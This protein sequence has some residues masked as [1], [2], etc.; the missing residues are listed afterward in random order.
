MILRK[1]KRFK[2]ADEKITNREQKWQKRWADAN[3]FTADIKNSSK[4]KKYLLIEFPYPSGIGLHIGHMLPFTSMDVMARYFRRKGFEVLYPMGF[5]SLGISAENYAVKVNRHPRDTVT[6]LCKTFERQV[7]RI[8][9][10]FDWSK[11]LAT[12]DPEFIKW[13]QWQF[14]Q[15]WKAGLAYKSPLPINW[16]PNCRTTMTNEDL[17]DGRCERCKG[18]VEK[19]MKSQWNLAITKYADRLIDDLDTLT[20]WPERVKVQQVNWIG[21]S[22]GADV[23]FIAN[24]EKLTVFTTRIDTIFGVSFMVLAPEHPLVLKWLNKSAIENSEE[25]KNYI[26]HAAAKSEIERVDATREK[27]GVRIAGITVKNPFNNIEIPVFIA[28]YVLGD[29]GYGAVMGVPAHDQRDWE[30]AKKF[31]LSIVPVLTGGDISEHAWEEDGL[32]INSDFM[33]G[34]NKQDAIAAALEFGKGFARSAKQYKLKDWGFSRQMYWGEPIPMVYCEKCGWQPVPDDQLPVLQPHI[35]NYRPTETGESPL[36][37]ATDWIDTTC[38]KC[39]GKAQRETDTMP[40]WAGSS[41]YYMRYLDPTDAQNFANRDDLNH[42]MPVDHYHGGAEHITRHLLYSR[43]WYK[44][45]SDLGLVP[46]I[47]PYKKKTVTGL[48][49]AEDGTKMS[50]SKGNVIDPL[51]VA[52]QVGADILR[53]TTLFLGPIEMNMSWSA[54]T[55]TGVQRFLKR[56]ENFSDNLIDEAPDSEQEFLINDLIAKV[57]SRINNMQFNTAI[58]A[59]MEYINAFS[60]AMPR[61]AYEALLHML[62]PF[63]P[64]LAEEMWEKIGHTD[65]LAR[66]PWPTMDESK[67]V[68]ATQTLAVSVSGKHRGE[69]TVAANALEPEIIDYAKE[70][71]KKYLTDDIVKTIF[72]PGKMVNFVVK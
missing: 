56:V 49:L 13:T 68:R 24:G 18:P 54:D 9:L 43:F 50:K 42:W 69:V 22:Y 17:E 44:A 35:D 12:S 61:V 53:T 15:F 65:M 3:A 46:G 30:F 29:Y 63:A 23:D 8:G 38:P 39:S 41:W 7:R 48:M 62:N 34:M 19:K 32:H 36:A 70:A 66:Y 45:L 4:P 26:A 58:S 5:D 14:I 25:V 52:E 16:C 71:V 51:T 72:V 11:K 55:M 59:M 28:D 60:N 47:E 6:E 67:L 31:N 21:R 64:H 27:T 10:S 20:D 57:S 40:Q 1:Q 37:R 33:N 2:M